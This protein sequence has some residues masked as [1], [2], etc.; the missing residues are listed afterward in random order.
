MQS[1]RRSGQT[2]AARV[3]RRATSGANCAPCHARKGAQGRSCG[4]AAPISVHLDAGQASISEAAQ[5]VVAYSVMHAVGMV[6]DRAVEHEK[7]MCGST[8]ATQCSESPSP[9]KVV[10]HRLVRGERHRAVEV[11]LPALEPPAA[12]CASRR[13]SRGRKNHRARALVEVLA[14]E[15][16][17]LERGPAR[18]GKRAREVSRAGETAHARRRREQRRC[19]AVKGRRRRERSSRPR[20]CRGSCRAR[21]LASGDGLRATET[22]ARVSGGAERAAAAAHACSDS[23]CQ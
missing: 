18:R 17:G 22:H 6:E 16:L 13:A 14:A 9:R 3:N 7:R 19:G 10:R 4:H 15:V 8:P 5:L 1:T 20:S 2:V 12:A 11:G 21:F 23:R